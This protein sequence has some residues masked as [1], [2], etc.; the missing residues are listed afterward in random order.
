MFLA[1]GELMARGSNTLVFEGAE[2]GAGLSFFDV[3][4]PPSAGAALHYHPYP[5]TWIIHEGSVEFT[6]A[7][8]IKCLSERAVVVVPAGT[9]HGFR[10]VGS[11]RL[12]MSCLHASEQFIT[13]WADHGQRE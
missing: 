2:F 11:G 8:E 10:N 1:A 6:L 12:R 7:G 9:I 3:D 13:T 5:E 4:L